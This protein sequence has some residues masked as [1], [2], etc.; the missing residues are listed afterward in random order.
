MDDLQFSISA[1][2]SDGTRLEAMFE[3]FRQF[4]I[5]IE[6]IAEALAQ[7]AASEWANAEQKHHRGELRVAYRVRHNWKKSDLSP[8]ATLDVNGPAQRRMM[9]LSG[10]GRPVVRPH[11][12]LENRFARK[13]IAFQ[14]L[15]NDSSTELERRKAF[16]DW[17]WFEYNVEALYRGEHGRAKAQGHRGASRFAETEVANVLCISSSKVHRICG[18]IRRIPEGDNGFPPMTLLDFETWMRTGKNPSLDN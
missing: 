1:G 14:I 13:A 6:Q 18:K 3:T 12:S 9:R 17:P 5:K 16:K 11:E 4:V 8:L 10:T 2:A 15:N 7:A